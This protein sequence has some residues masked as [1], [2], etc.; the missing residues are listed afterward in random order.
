M[1]ATIY[2][3]FAIMFEGEARP[4]PEIYGPMTFQECHKSKV[5]GQKYANRLSDSDGRVVHLL[6]VCITEDQLRLKSI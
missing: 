2:F 6:A 4:P 3:I 1:T 5:W